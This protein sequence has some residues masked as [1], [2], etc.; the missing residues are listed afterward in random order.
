MRYKLTNRTIISGAALALLCMQGCMTSSASLSANKALALSASALSGSESYG[1]AGEVSVIDP[2]GSVGSKAAYEGKVTLHGN[3][4]LQWK[5]SATHS[6]SVKSQNAMSYQPLK[7][8][9]Y[10]NGKSAEITYAETPI[11]N[12]PVH[13]QI[14][15]DDNVARERVVAGLRADLALLRSDKELLRGDPKE[16]EK[17]LSNA[18]KRLE[19]AIATLK[20]KTVCDWTA[21][22]KDWFPD[23]LRE[24]TILTYSWDGKPF[25][26]KRIAETNFLHNAQDGTMKKV[27]K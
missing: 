8:L 9:E 10:I 11:P 17:I 19:T 18:G 25:R 2:G 5:N 24:E 4:Q 15:L 6:A 3:M 20:V 27:N 26:E 22:P 12:R 14:K 1:F 13:L 21:D 16:A 7:L 23:R